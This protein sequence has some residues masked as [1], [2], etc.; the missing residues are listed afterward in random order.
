[1]IVKIKNMNEVYKEIE[2]VEVRMK[3]INK[4]LDNIKKINHMLILGLQEIMD[5]AN[6]T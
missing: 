3:I 2:N 6:L 1:M 5:E 4:E